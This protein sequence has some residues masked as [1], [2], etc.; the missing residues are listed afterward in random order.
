MFSVAV[1]TISTLCFL[2]MPCWGCV[3]ASE[4]ACRLRM[5]DL[6]HHGSKGGQ[7]STQKN[8]RETSRKATIIVVGV[9]LRLH[10]IVF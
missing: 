2:V 8:I 10:C 5:E 6:R 9:L 4:Y 7:A 3:G 1:Y